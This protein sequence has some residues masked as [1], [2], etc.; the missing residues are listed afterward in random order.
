MKIFISYRQ[1]DSPGDCRQLSERLRQRF[2]RENVFFDIDSIRLGDNWW[3]VAR[4][5]I[6]ASD[7]LLVP[8]GQSWLTIKNK[9]GRRKIDDPSDPV[10]RE[11]ALALK[12][13]LRMV[14]VLVEG[15]GMPD[16]DQLPLPLR[17]FADLTAYELRHR[18]FDRDVEALID[19]LGA[20]SP[21]ST[22]ATE[23]PLALLGKSFAAKLGE[24]LAAAATTP[25]QGPPAAPVPAY[26]PSPAMNLTGTWQSPTGVTHHIRQQG[27][28]VM[29]ESRN[30]FG[31]VI[32]QGQ[33]TLSNNQLHI[34]YNATYQPPFVVR[35]EARCMVSPDGSVI[36]G[37]CMD[38]GAGMQQVFMRRVG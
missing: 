3:T 38:P 26:A 1:N 5:R 9:A 31:M 10:H 7:V 15:A 19:E 37:Q 36:T 4:E 22:P 20:P 17:E 32:I 11:L 28:V 13:Q 2:G 23:S 27:N 14:P 33:G 25:A 34:V 21:A 18:S 6:R 35:G 12:E 8:I 24:R 29:I 30:P 16:A